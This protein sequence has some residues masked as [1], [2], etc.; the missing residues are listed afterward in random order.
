MKKMEI[1]HKIYSVMSMNEFVKNQDI[2]NPKSVAIE[3]NE[4]K[5]VLPI[6]NKNIDSGPG[7]YYEGPNTGF[8]DIEKPSEDDEHN[9]S[10]EKVIDLSNPKNIGEVIS[11][12][13]MIKDLQ[14]DLMVSPTDSNVF[15]LNISQN[16]TPEMAALKKAINA[17]QINKKVYEDRFP[18]FQNDMRLLRGNSITLAKMISIC[19]GFDIACEITL[20]DR[21][22]AVNPM[23]TEITI[24]LTENRPAKN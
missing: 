5:T 14:S 23:N 8:I 20:R 18:Q 4:G 9:Y 11:K 22:K 12:S 3:L 1:E 16:D 15:H 2:L 6:K 17:K 13:N 7:V 21:D 24:D 19:D 10:A